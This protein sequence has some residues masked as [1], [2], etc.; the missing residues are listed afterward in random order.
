MPDAATLQRFDVLGIHVTAASMASAIDQICRWVDGDEHTYVCVS[1]A[2]SI[3][4]AT[5]DPALRQIFNESGM[6]L[7][8]GMPL[9]WSG[10]RA[11]L[12]EMTRVCGPDLMPAMLAEA[13]RHGWSSYFYGGAPG[14]AEQLVAR[15]RE[16]I[17]ELRVAGVASPP[18]RALS[19][20]ELR[21]DID[22]INRSGA[23]IVWVGLG[24]PKQERWMADNRHLLTAPVLIGVGAAF[25]MHA[26]RVQ[27]APQWMQ[28]SG[29]EWVYRLCREPRRLWR[30]YARVVPRFLWGSLWHRPRALAVAGRVPV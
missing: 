19:D 20:D 29:L 30:R 22:T 25:D 3:I 1:D 6:T 9:V 14:V 11:G 24:A 5:S 23:D 10:H 26:G 15:L 17:P 4:S 21:D 12:H 7:P 16:Q 27:R 28:R 18:Y 2:N 13:A 8:D